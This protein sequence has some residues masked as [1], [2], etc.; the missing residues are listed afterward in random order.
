[1]SGIDSM[2]NKSSNSLFMF[3]SGLVKAGAW[4]IV[5]SR[6]VDIKEKQVCT[7]VKHAGFTLVEVLMTVVIV[8]VAAA[9]A[10]VSTNV[11]M[12]FSNKA[13]DNTRVDSAIDQD[14]ASLERAAFQYTYCTGSYKW[15]ATPCGSA[16][17][18]TQNYYF[19]LTTSIASANADAFK[20][21]CKNVNG[22][23]TDA[24]RAAMNGGDSSLA[25]SAAAQNLG[26]SRQVTLDSPDAHRLLIDYIVSGSVK[27]QKSVVP[28]AAYW[29]HDTN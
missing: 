1:M 4:Q 20:D 6:C 22:S 7:R 18:G 19:P 10:A 13:L 12:R 3:S 28:V 5:R 21:A 2:A 24:L 25:L 16:S 9:A 26:I 29:C 17:P 23:M 27:R 11:A 8:A 14:L 15:D